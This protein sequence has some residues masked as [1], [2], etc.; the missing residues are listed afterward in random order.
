MSTTVEIA[1]AL[2]R[3]HECTAAQLAVTRSAMCVV[4][5]EVVATHAIVPCGHK[6]VCYAC[7]AAVTKHGVYSSCPI[8]I[9]NPRGHSRVHPGICDCCCARDT[10][11]LF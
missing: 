9:V 3:K 11:A 1:L 4:C 10:N 6:C 5:E 2:C 8:S 7:V